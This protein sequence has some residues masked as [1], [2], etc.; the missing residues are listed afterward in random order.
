MVVAKTPFYLL[1][2]GALLTAFYMTRQVGYVFFGAWRGGRPAHES[3]AVMTLPLVILAFFAMALG[4]IGT[5]LW[6]WFHAFLDGTP[7]AFN[8]HAFAEPGLLL[9]MMSSSLVVFLGLGLGWW[10]YGG[11]APK[12]EE[13]DVLEKATPMPWAWLRDRLYADEL[14]GATVIAFYDWW[15]R[16]PKISFLSTPC[17][18][19]CN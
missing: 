10:L 9:L 11:Q 6:P 17:L 5:P 14:Y 3:R 12:P 15:A 18:K 4:L 16:V 13:P 2:F 1:V 19:K 8:L 7:A